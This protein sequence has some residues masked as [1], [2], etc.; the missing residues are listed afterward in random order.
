MK[1]SRK[2]DPLYRKGPEEVIP[3]LQVTRDSPVELDRKFGYIVTHHTMLASAEKKLKD[4][5]KTGKCKSVIRVQKEKVANNKSW[6]TFS[7]ETLTNHVRHAIARCTPNSADGI[8]LREQGRQRKRYCANKPLRFRRP[9][10][11][12]QKKIRYYATILEEY[13][14][15][16]RPALVTPAATMRSWA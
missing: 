3:W 15:A 6:L 7:V 8:L 16:R 9:S 13:K 11:P 10:K 12:A 2:Q 4:V 14:L 5:I 1:T